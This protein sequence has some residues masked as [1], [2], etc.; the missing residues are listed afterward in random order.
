MEQGLNI[1]QGSYGAKRQTWKKAN[2]R[3]IL[4][5]IRRQNPRADEAELLSL[6][7]DEVRGNQ[8]IVGTIIEYWFANNLRALS[9]HEPTI[10]SAH[11][12]AIASDVVNTIK[13]RVEDKAKIALLEWVMPNGKRLK[14]CTREQCLQ[15]AEKVGPWLKQ[16]AAACKPRQRVGD[17]MKENDLKALY[18]QT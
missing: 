11:R 15:L 9:K 12:N 3:E 8:E 13:Q 6:F 16:V 17:V 10:S 14:D 7:V 1:D 4:N 5:D 18:N 2:P